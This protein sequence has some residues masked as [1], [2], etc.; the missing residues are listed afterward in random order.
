LPQQGKTYTGGGVDRMLEQDRQADAE[1]PEW[2]LVEASR[3]IVE[4]EDSDQL[5]TD[6]AK[7]LFV[8]YQKGCIAKKIEITSEMIE[9]G[10]SLLLAWEQSS[11][12]ERKPLIGQIYRAMR[13][14]EPSR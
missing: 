7:R 9:A 8:L 3:L 5:S 10:F 2:I 13:Q 6:L 14:I 1:M 12:P 4:W 11:D